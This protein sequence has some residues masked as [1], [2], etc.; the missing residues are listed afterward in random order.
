MKNAAKQRQTR[1]SL[2]AEAARN[3]AGNGRKSQARRKTKPLTVSRQGLRLQTKLIA[4]PVQGE[5]GERSE[6]GGV[7]SVQEK[8]RSTE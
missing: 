6:V 3:G 1:G 4:S 7:V 2:F 8:T 5:V